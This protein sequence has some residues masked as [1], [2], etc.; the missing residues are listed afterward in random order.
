M[1]KQIPPGEECP[2]PRIT[3]EHEYRIHSAIDKRTNKSTIE[4]VLCDPEEEDVNKSVVKASISKGC[5]TVQELKKKCKLYCDR[6]FFNRISDDEWVEFTNL[7]M[8]DLWNLC[9]N[10]W[11]WTLSD[12]HEVELEDGICEYDLPHDFNNFLYVSS[13]S[14]TKCC[15]PK[16]M[17]QIVEPTQIDTVTGY[18]V[19][20][21]YNVYKDKPTM[22]VRLPCMDCCTPPTCT[23]S[24]P[25]TG[26]LCIKYFTSPPEVYDLDDKICQIPRKWGT[27]D[28]L[29][30][31][32][33]QRVHAY[34][35]QPFQLDAAFQQTLAN[36]KTIDSGKQTTNPI[37]RSNALKF[38]L[39]RW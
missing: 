17:F 31:L 37:K 3:Q 23:C 20:F 35:G 19:A 18:A 39:R 11:N 10:G 15:P 34:E 38:N 29:A 26:K 24:C 22:I 5:L 8:R 33:A 6:L 4:K 27:V 13:C 32:V 2:T 7:A 1:I 16:K 14:D 9:P 21:S 36:L 25:M 28:L 12:I 30:Q